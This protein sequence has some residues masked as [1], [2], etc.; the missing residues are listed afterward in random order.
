MQSALW[1]YL[2]TRV[3][4]FHDLTDTDINRMKALMETY[5]DTPMDLADASLVATAEALDIRRIFTLDSDF[6]VYRRH[7]REPFE[8]VPQPAAQ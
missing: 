2:A 6:A 4:V 5:R 3:F 1:H 7:G 8:I